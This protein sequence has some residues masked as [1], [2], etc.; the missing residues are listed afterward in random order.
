MG[1]LVALVSWYPAPFVSQPPK[2]PYPDSYGFLGAN[3]YT[4][5][6]DSIV[7]YGLNTLIRPHL[8]YWHFGSL[9]HPKPI[10]TKV[11][12]MLTPNLCLISREA[13]KL[14]RKIL[15]IMES[16]SRLYCQT[17]NSITEKYK[18]EREITG[19]EPHW[20]K[21]Q[22]QSWTLPTL[23]QGLGENTVLSL[24]IWSCKKVSTFFMLC[25]SQ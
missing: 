18:K 16:S 14:E 21:N 12:S 15:R 7:S 17:P 10:R 2:V 6:L 13:S 9:S 24:Q 23:R 19:P 1:I 5:H 22:S 11:W 4:I 25:A 20:D 8:T 3:W